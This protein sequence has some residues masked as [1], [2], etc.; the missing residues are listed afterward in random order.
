MAASSDSLRIRRLLIEPG[1]RFQIRLTKALPQDRVSAHDGTPTYRAVGVGVGV[2]NLLDESIRRRIVLGIEAP[3]LRA[4][5]QGL[6]LANS[7]S[8]GTELPTPLLKERI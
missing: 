6:Y 3:T 7:A 2:Q 5:I 8:S 1:L 4:A